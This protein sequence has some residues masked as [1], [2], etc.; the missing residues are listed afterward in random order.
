MSSL[1]DL[2][3]T[4]VVIDPALA[5]DPDV[6]CEVCHE[7]FLEGDVVVPVPVQELSGEEWVGLVHESCSHPATPAT[8]MTLAEFLR[9]AG[10]V[11]A[12]DANGEPIIY[13]TGLS[14]L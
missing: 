11:P 13:S 1:T 8:S 4:P 9:T 10:P 12:F 14:L 2:D 6:Q 5:S 7:N 3:R